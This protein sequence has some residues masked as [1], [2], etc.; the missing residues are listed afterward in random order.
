MLGRLK[1]TATSDSILRLRRLLVELDR[2]TKDVTTD[3]DCEEAVGVGRELWRLVHR[4]QKALDTV[5]VIARKNAPEQP[6]VHRIE[7]EGKSYCTVSV[8]GPKATMR[9]GVDIDALR[10]VLNGDFDRLFATRI[11]IKPRRDFEGEVPGLEDQARSAA[12]NA[13]NL[14]A[15]KPRVSF[16]K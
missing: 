12:L 6:G 16:P 7:G 8:S 11:S 10:R 14:S 9:S 1:M 5:K 4:A 13:V 3:T 15:G 2:L